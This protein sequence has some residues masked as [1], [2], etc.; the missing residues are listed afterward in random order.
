MGLAGPGE[1]DEK[2]SLNCS[3]ESLCELRKCYAT[4]FL[5]PP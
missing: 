4:C 3:S 2:K 1:R 5:I